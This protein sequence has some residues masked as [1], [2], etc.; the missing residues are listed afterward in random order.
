[1]VVRVDELNSYAISDSEWESCAK[2]CRFLQT[3]ASVTEAQSGC[4]YVSMSM[5]VRSFKHLENANNSAM[6]DPILL[7][8]AAAMQKKLYSY[9]GVIISDIYK[10]A[11]IFDP[12]FSNDII[13]DSDTLRRHIHL[14]STQQVTP[15]SPFTTTVEPERSL[16]E[17][18][19]DEDSMGGFSIDDEITRY[20]R[21]TSVGDK[22]AAPL[23]WWKLNESRFPTIAAVARDVLAIQASSVASESAFSQAGLLIDDKRTCLGDD[24]IKAN[25]LIK[26]WRKYVESSQKMW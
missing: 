5:C 21:A 6:D 4:S 19:L 22:R 20:L 16:F 14:D 12:R 2:I 13:R 15:P 1:M 17:K 3:A 9:R 10:L 25:M 18:L 7:P 24:S 8:I 26:S 11:Q 23:I